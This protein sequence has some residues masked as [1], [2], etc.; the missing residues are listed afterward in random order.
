M[1]NNKMHLRSCINTGICKVHSTHKQEYI[2]IH[3]ISSQTNTAC[4]NLVFQFVCDFMS[5][6]VAIVFGSICPAAA[7]KPFKYEAFLS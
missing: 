5:M 2:Q 4:K 6:S 1:Y 3:S 7:E